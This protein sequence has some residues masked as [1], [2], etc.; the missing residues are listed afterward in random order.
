MS[1]SHVLRGK[2]MTGHESE[3]RLGSSMSESWNL[4]HKSQ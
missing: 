4:S 2:L 3:Q 1:E